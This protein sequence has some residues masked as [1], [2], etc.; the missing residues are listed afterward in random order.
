ME[1]FREGLRILTGDIYKI[2]QE[3]TKYPKSNDLDSTLFEFNKMM[4]EW[5]VN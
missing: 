3:N 5:A 4:Q 2:H 1:G